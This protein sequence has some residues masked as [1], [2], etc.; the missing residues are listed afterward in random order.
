MSDC[1]ECKCCPLC[2][3]HLKTLQAERDRVTAMLDKIATWLNQPRNEL[4]VEALQALKDYTAQKA[5]TE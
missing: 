1:I 5:G 2:R 4:E 3:V